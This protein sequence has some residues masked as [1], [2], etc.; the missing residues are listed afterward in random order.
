MVLDLILVHSVQA[1]FPTS[2]LNKNGNLTT[3]KGWDALVID[4]VS[5]IISGLVH[6]IH[7][8]NSFVSK[9]QMFPRENN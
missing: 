4:N 9:S 7:S 3:L 5:L 2:L 8:T 6:C 1:Y